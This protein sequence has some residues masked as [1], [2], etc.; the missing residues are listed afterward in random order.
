[1]IWFDFACLCN[2]SSLMHIYLNEVH[3]KKRRTL[4]RLVVVVVRRN[5]KNNWQWNNRINFLCF[6]FFV[7]YLIKYKKKTKSRSVSS[8]FLHIC[9]TNTPTSYFLLLDIQ[10]VNV[11]N[12][13]KKKIIIAP[14]VQ[15]WLY[16]FYVCERWRFM[17]VVFTSHCYR[18]PCFC[19]DCHFNFEL[20]PRAKR[21]Q[22]P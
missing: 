10:V 9:T 1:M 8:S 22:L 2:N 14:A 17:W 19:F 15:K 18:F 21:Q 12:A 7:C 13:Y 6:T 11:Q 16:P 3:K 4:R 5:N 20:Q